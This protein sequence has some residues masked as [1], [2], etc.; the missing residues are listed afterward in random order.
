MNDVIL[1]VSG[2][3]DPDMNTLMARGKRPQADY[4]AMARA[5]GADLIDYAEARRRMGRVET[6]LQKIGGPNL[7]LAWSCFKRRKQ[8]RVIFTD[9]EQ[10][11]IPLA[12][13][14]KFASI[15]P[16]PRHLMIS[17]NLSPFKK[18]P[19]FD[20]LDVQSHI[21][22]FFVYASWQ[23]QF[24]ET[25]WNICSNRVVLT[26]FRVD[27]EFFNPSK[28]HKIATPNERIRPDKPTVCAVGLE[29]RD[30]PTFIAAVQGLDIQVVIAAASPWS[31]RPNTA[32]NQVISE[33]VTV[34]SLNWFELR[35]LYA[36]SECVVVP[37]FDVPFQ[38]GVTTILEAMA[39]EKAVIC[40]RTAGQTDVIVEGETGLYVSPQDS[41][42]LREAIVSLLKNP[43]RAKQMGKKGRL[44]V[45]RAMNLESY[46]AR[47]REFV[48][49][50]MVT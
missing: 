11:G 50:A 2:V 42:A 18:R 7:L 31:K 30:Y 39:M 41:Q 16:R 5:F 29:C 3:I 21:D 44:Q 37:L 35:R 12:L 13:L 15:G 45:E 20:W 25:R 6:G 27:T 48:N 34:C 22:T 36:M 38:A 33:N 28:V 24:I 46:A 23:K 32:A 19:F 43:A 49:Q 47:L 10:V 14:L 1:T 9:G 17:H 4:L 40:S 8:Y 26:P